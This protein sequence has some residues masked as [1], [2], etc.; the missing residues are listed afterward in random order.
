MRILIV[1]AAGEGSR[2]RA[3]GYENPKPFIDCEGTPMLVRAV[4]AFRPH[5][6]QVV[7]IA[8]AEH[9]GFYEGRVP[10]DWKIVVQEFLQEGAALS[11]MS[12][13]GKV[14]DDAEV[15]VINSDQ[16]FT[17]EANVGAWIEKASSDAKVRGFAGS[18][19]TFRTNGGPWSYAE[20]ST[21]DTA[22][23]LVTRVAEKVAISDIATCGAY[24]FRSWRTLR[25]AIMSMVTNEN[26][27]NGEFYLAPAYNEILHH[28]VTTHDVPAGSFWSVGTP[29]LLSQWLRRGE[30]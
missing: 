4:G 20:L 7:V 5:V 8:R 1:P 27:H 24:F 22:E 25:N 10:A 12:V 14:P 2:F 13:L 15:V 18:I 30:A 9:A 6:D 11:V 21:A 3:E 17:P 28:G 29:E 23:P 26:R 16:F 19:L